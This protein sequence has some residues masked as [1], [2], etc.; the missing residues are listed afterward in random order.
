ML[1]NTKIWLISVLIKTLNA[2]LNVVVEY[3]LNL[4]A[5]PYADVKRLSGLICESDKWRMVDNHHQCHKQAQGLV[6]TQEISCKSD[7]RTDE[8]HKETYSSSI[9]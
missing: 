6:K 7:K 8:F 1:P 3:N 9:L 2:T 5:S 4:Q